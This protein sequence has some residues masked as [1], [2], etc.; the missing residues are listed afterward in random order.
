[1]SL[2][3]PPKSILRKKKEVKVLPKNVVI[4]EN[5]DPLTEQRLKVLNG[6]NE[7]HLKVLDNIPKY[8]TEVTKNQQQLKFMITELTKSVVDLVKSKNDNEEKNISDDDKASYIPI[9]K[10]PIDKTNTEVK[11]EETEMAP[12]MD[13]LEC[14]VAIDTPKKRGRGRPPKTRNN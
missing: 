4:K 7:R 8:Y 12:E 2:L 5:T 11:E 13:V 1:M 14:E 6:L 3:K 10:E 9:K